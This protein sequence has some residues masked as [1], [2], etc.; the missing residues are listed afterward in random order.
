MAAIVIH[1][2]PGRWFGV[3]YVAVAKEKSYAGC[4]FIR[5]MNNLQVGGYTHIYTGNTYKE[6]TYF[7]S[8]V[9]ENVA[10][11]HVPSFYKSWFASDS[12][13]FFSLSLYFLLLLFL[14]AMCSIRIRKKTHNNNVLFVFLI[15]CE[16]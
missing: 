4:C 6:N 11:A 3:V 2:K 1:V 16:I 9:W 14:Y 7:H 15:N 10:V 8:S 5:C 13:F 12:I